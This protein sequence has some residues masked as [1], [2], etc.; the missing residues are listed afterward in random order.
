M[1]QHKFQIH[2][3]IDKGS[4]EANGYGCRCMHMDEKLKKFNIIVRHI[5]IIQGLNPQMQNNGRL[6]HRLTTITMGDRTI[7]K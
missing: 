6:T 5:V 7:L 3:V 1:T 2:K 4:I